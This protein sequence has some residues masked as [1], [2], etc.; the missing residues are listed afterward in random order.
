MEGSLTIGKKWAKISRN[1]PGRNENSV[2]NRFIT[3]TKNIKFKSRGKK[4]DFNKDS[5]FV[6][7]IKK[8]I[9]SLKSHI[10]NESLNKSL[11][12]L[13]LN[14]PESS[15]SPERKSPLKSQNNEGFR[16]PSWP[17]E[18]IADI[19]QNLTNTDLINN[20]VVSNYNNYLLYMQFLNNK[21]I[22]PQPQLE[23][24]YQEIQKEI[25][26]ISQKD[27]Y[28]SHLHFSTTSSETDRR[29]SGT[30]SKGDPSSKR[31]SNSYTSL[32]TPS[33]ISENEELHSKAFF[34]GNGN[35]D[36]E[37]STNAD[38]HQ[39]HYDIN[40]NNINSLPG[41]KNPPLNPKNK[42]KNLMSL[43]VDEMAEVKENTMN[44]NSPEAFNFNMTQS[45]NR[46][47]PSPTPPIM[48]F[49][50]VSPMALN[51]LNQDYFR[52]SPNID[53]NGMEKRVLSPIPSATKM[54][55]EEMPLKRKK[56]ELFRI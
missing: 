4:S 8:I 35:G 29:G 50:N 13:V 56:M 41:I 17:K 33:V 12:N 1:L 32:L 9:Q 7:E 52:F 39:N 43:V 53:N 46:P 6:Q 54:E 5:L 55:E 11:E 21:V 34:K 36:M 48:S 23:K 20:L 14:S 37:I 40:N 24:Q 2:K 10:S 26:S 49:S 28:L 16:K 25:K 22:S 38:S 27:L 18:N 15:P 42:N 44:A 31:P 30:T 45:W 47:F 51:T 3:L 19:N